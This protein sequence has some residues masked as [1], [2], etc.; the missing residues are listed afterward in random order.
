MGHEEL[1]LI[2]LTEAARRLGISRVTMSNL[3]K[4]GRFTVYESGYDR[5]LKLVSMAEVEAALAP[6]PI[7]T[8]GDA[9][10]EKS[11]HGG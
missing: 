7:Q 5:R 3:A 9:E 6:R 10:A 2:P 4:A 8:A 1:E 11:G